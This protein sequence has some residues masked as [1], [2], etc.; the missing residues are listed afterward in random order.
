MPSYQKHWRGRKRS[1]GSRTDY[2][3]QKRRLLYGAGRA[4]RAIYAKTS[5]SITSVF[6]FFRGKTVFVS[7]L[8]LLGFGL[9]ILLLLGLGAVAYY[10]K[11]L[12]NPD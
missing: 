11:D 10:S 9:A 5:R 12:P 8:K 3:N 6:R 7:L 1:R 2:F 4:Q